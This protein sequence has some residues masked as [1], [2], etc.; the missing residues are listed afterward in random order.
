MASSLLP[1]TRGR[2]AIRA[3]NSTPWSCLLR[4]ADE[5]QRR[6]V[7]VGERGG[8]PAKAVRQEHDLVE[9]HQGLA[10]VGGFVD[11][12]GNGQQ[13]GPLGKVGR[14]VGGGKVPDNRRVVLVG[15]T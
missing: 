13:P 1:S 8:G 5:S 7:H 2:A 9:L 4:L 15:G 14:R 6:L 10:V 3:A 12:P 11:G